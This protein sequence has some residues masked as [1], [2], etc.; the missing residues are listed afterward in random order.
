MESVGRKNRILKSDSIYFNGLFFSIA[1]SERQT[2]PVIFDSKAKKC[3][4]LKIAE[5]V[6]LHV[7]RAPI[8]TRQ[9]Q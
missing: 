1:K 7:V 8:E 9:Q 3:S 4:G 2:L 6:F 5:H